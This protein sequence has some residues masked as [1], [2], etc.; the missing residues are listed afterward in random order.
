MIFVFGSNLSGVH[1]AGAAKFASLK[2]G[3]VMGT[4]EGPTGNSYALPTKDKNIE[5]RT[6]EE[7]RKSVDTFIQY[8]TAHPEDTY[9]ITRIG[10]GLAGFAD[11]EIAP[12]FANVPENCLFDAAWESYLPNARFW[13]TF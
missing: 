3:A 4:G 8:A 6:L 10:C 5:T 12:L 11:D 2:H 9:R 7:V 13:G 1:G